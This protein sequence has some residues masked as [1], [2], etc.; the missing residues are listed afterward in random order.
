MDRQQGPTVE[1]RE[2]YSLSYDKPQWKRIFKK[3]VCVCIYIYIYICMYVC[4]YITESL[5]CTAEINISIV[6]QLYMDYI[7]HAILRA[8]ILE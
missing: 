1:P 3:N 2:L 7:Q 6:Y 5:Y 4:M 8:R